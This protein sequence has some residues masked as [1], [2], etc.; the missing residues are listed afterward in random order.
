[1]PDGAVNTTYEFTA[2]DVITSTKLNN[3]LDQ[4][5]MTTTAI[6][7]GTLEVASG[8]LKVASQGITSNELGN[9]SVKTIAIENGAVTT[10][11][12]A[13]STGASDGVTTAKLA[14]GS[15]TTTKIADANITAAK[16]DGAQTGSAPIYGVRA[17]AS[18][19]GTATTPITPISSG[20]IS[21]I[22]RNSTGAYT[23][24]LV[25]PMS[26]SNYCVVA[27]ATHNMGDTYGTNCWVTI[28]D[29]SVFGISTGK[30]TGGV[31]YNSKL[32]SF[33]VMQ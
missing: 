14:T 31:T 8:K 30:V 17:Y 13:D 6:V 19:D 20:N 7:G 5:F 16:L 22:V 18:F 2:T 1:M 23:I 29:S 10:A 25:T 15:V 12:I 24:T 28:T 21:S 11:K 33:V 26:S 32:I 4:S 27:N 3:V 9:G